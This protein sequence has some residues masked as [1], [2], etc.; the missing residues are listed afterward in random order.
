MLQFFL[1][2]G[3][4][5]GKLVENLTIPSNFMKTDRLLACS[6]LVRQNTFNCG[7]TLELG[8][9]TGSLQLCVV[10]AINRLQTSPADNPCSSPETVTY[11]ARQDNAAISR[12]ISFGK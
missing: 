6:K 10:R 1:G 5:A 3:G 12:V 8:C 4:G 9:G 11:H 7:L 2:G